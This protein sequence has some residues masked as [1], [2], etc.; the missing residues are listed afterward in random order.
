MPIRTPRLDIRLLQEGD[1]QVL[2]QAK[3]ETWDDLARVFAWASERQTLEQDEVYVRQCHARAI[4]REDFNMMG[5]E[6]ETKKPVIWAGIH[7]HDWRTKEFQ[8]GFWVRKSA[9]QQGF[10]LETANALA[11]Y[12]FAV[13]K[14]NRLVACHKE[15][16]EATGKVVKKLGF[17]YEGVRKNSLFVAGDQVVNAV[18]YVK[19]TPDNFPDMK[20]IWG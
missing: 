8:I 11:R 12:S 10:A 5:I 1:G 16:N 3:A 15:G 4:L 13:F 14:P 19:T 17:E 9:Q 20:V 18:W 2:H 6:R 7:C